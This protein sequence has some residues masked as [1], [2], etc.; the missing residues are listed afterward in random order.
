M[1]LREAPA[2]AIT[3][4]SLSLVSPFS[5]R[6]AAARKAIGA[7]TWISAGSATIVISRKV[8]IAWPLEVTTSSLASTWVTHSVAITAHSARKKM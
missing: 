7:T 1:V 5:V 6:I 3:G 4:S 8:Q 2:A